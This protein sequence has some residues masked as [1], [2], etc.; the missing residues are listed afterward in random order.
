MR[1]QV[2]ETAATCHM[3]GYESVNGSHGIGM[4]VMTSALNIL[5]ILGNLTDL[6]ED[7]FH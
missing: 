7:A 1:C 2:T 3:Y 6:S 5:T 4:S